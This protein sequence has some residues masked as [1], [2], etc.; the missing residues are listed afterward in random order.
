[1]Q[2]ELK[3]YTAFLSVLQ[4]A[5]YG[6]LFHLCGV[7]VILMISSKWTYDYIT[8]KIILKLSLQD[9]FAGTV[10]MTSVW[11]GRDSPSHRLKCIE[12]TKW[13]Q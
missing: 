6:M 5:S 8:I 1:M 3:F 2:E 12:L 10:K 4:T 9:I 13:F 11:I 7:K